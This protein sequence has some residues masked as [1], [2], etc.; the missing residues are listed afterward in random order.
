MTGQGEDLLAWLDGA[1]TVRENAARAALAFGDA[2]A[3]GSE[4]PDC[5]YGTGPGGPYMRVTVPG[6]E[7]QTEAAVAHFALHD[8]ASVLR[9]CASDRKLIALHNVPSVVFPDSGHHE[10]ERRCVGCGFGS[11]EEPMVDDVNDCP[12]LNYIAEGYGRT[13]GEG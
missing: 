13:E 3:A 5:V 6:F 11:D 8:P 4:A 9:R 12:V 2:F 7:G 1:I 10:G